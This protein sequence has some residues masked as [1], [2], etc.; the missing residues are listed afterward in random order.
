MYSGYQGICAHIL[1]LRGKMNFSQV[2]CF[3]FRVKIRG[4][5]RVL[6]NDTK[7]NIVFFLF[8]SSKCTNT[9]A[10]LTVDTKICLCVHRVWLALLSLV[11]LNSIPGF[12]E[13]SFQNIV[14]CLSLQIP[15][16]FML[17]F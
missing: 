12:L 16:E 4:D 13:D 9:F 6:L 1:I 7:F 14:I 17:L 11:T 2:L 8:L 15:V 5:V 10:K 3:K